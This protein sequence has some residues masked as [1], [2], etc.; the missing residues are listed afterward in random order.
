MIG[1]SRTRAQVLESILQPSKEI[2]PLFATW[3]ITTKSG[4][5]FDGMLR[6]RANNVEVFVDSSRREFAPRSN[7]IVERHILKE[8]IMPSGLAQ[9]LTDLELR[10]LVATLLAKR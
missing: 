6:S 7:D 3:R 10:D 1:R 5:K 8:S 2:A 9:G 4:E